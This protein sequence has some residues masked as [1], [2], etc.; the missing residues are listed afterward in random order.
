MTGELVVFLIGMR[1]N[2][3]WRPDL[4]L[5]VFQAM[6]A[7]LAELSRDPDSGLAGLS[8][9]LR[10]AAARCWS[11]T[12]APT[13][14]STPTPAT[15]TPAPAG[16]GG[17][18]PA[19][20]K[21]PGSGR[22]LA[23]DVSGGPGRDPLLR[24][25]AV[26]TGRR[27]STVP[28]SRRGETARQR[29]ADQRIR[30]GTIRPGP[31]ADGGYPDRV[32]GAGWYADPS[33]RPDGFRWWDGDGW[34]RWLSRDAAAGRARAGTS[35]RADRQPAADGGGAG[36]R[37]REAAGR[38]GHRARRGRAGGDR[39]RRDRVVQHG[40]AADGAGRGPAAGR[41]GTDQDQL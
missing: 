35:A 24:D 28:V 38:G 7:M 30:P 5:P 23:R 15:R 41:S 17:V 18:Q 11:S 10:R 16:V 31:A 1:I 19:G 27:H 22:H 37:H 40:R 2:Q 4:W 34:T 20:R 39:G 6:P 21:A 33:G 26:R 32:S 8:A 3:P 29:L 13:S 36:H 9:D 14:G 25:A 12:G